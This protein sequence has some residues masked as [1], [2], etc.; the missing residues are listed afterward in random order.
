MSGYP[1]YDPTV[2]GLLVSGYT[3]TATFTP[4]AE[5]YSAN[6]VMEGPKELVF[7]DAAGNALPAGSLIRIVS[8]VQRISSDTVASGQTSFTG[9]LYSST[10]S[11]PHANKAAWGLVAADLA[12]Y[13]GPI[14]LGTPVDE[15]DDQYIKQQYVDTDVKLTGSSLFMEYVTDGAHTA[16]AVAHQ[17]TIYAVRL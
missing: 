1:V 9:R 10:P 2:A 14:A 11:S 7:T 4:T 15:G 6:T 3:A 5:A 16:A 12:I 13:R 17:V 8:T